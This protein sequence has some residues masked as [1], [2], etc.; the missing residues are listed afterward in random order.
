VT[1]PAADQHTAAQPKPS[2]THTLVSQT[3]TTQRDATTG[4]VQPNRAGARY[5]NK[6]D[7]DRRVG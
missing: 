5:E 6:V 1:L 2:A 7:D 3:M 4:Q